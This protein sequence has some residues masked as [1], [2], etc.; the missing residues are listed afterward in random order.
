MARKLSKPTVTPPIE[1]GI[2][3]IPGDRWAS[4]ETHTP[5]ALDAVAESIMASWHCPTLDEEL[6]RIIGNASIGKADPREHV[7]KAA[8]DVLTAI[9]HLNMVLATGDVKAAATRGIEVGTLDEQLRIKLNHEEKAKREMV[10]KAGKRKRDLERKSE[11]ATKAETCCKLFAEFT[12]A[13]IKKFGLPAV[14]RDVG[15]FA[16]DEM[17]LP[18]PIKLRTVRS[19]IE[20]RKS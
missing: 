20:K 18:E 1:T 9:Y 11:S 13:E 7:Q 3:R 5:E 15:K 6:R 16:A 2:Y 10:R 17:K 4:V 14:Y 12:P 19:Y 8:G